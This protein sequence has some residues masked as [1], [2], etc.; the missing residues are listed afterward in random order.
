[1]NL[2]ENGENEHGA[3]SISVP[4]VWRT[5]PP[6]F[7]SCDVFYSD[8]PWS[9]GYP[10]FNARAGGEWPPY[11]A[12]VLRLDRLALNLAPPVI[13]VVDR[14]FARLCHA[15]FTASLMLNG[16]PAVAASYR[17][18]IPVAFKDS[19]SLLELLA[20]RFRRVGDFMAGYGRTG[21]VFAGL[22][23]SFVLSDYN[24]HCIG[25]IA[26]HAPGWFRP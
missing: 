14:S 9:R 24:A 16:R 18:A 13:Y 5:L 21:R 11:T 19:E 15:D 23:G 6:E 25:Y 12:F 26:N 20:R 8:P 3:A 1:V 10:T 4:N 2:A 22:G 7:A 17:L